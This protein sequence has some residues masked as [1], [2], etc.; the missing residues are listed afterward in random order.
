MKPPNISPPAPPKNIP[1]AVPTPG[2]GINVP[3]APPIHVPRPAPIAIN[4]DLPNG[5]LNTNAFNNKSING[6]MKGIFLT[7]RLISFL[8]AFNILANNL[9]NWVGYRY[10]NSNYGELSYLINLDNIEI[11]QFIGG[12]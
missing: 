5:S 8:D 2:T 9:D 11:V 10:S 6:P 7:I 12:G 4:A 1:I 3:S